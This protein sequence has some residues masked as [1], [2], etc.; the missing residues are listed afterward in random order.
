MSSRRT[1]SWERREF[2]SS[3]APVETIEEAVVLSDPT[4]E[5]AARLL[6]EGEF[7]QRIT[8]VKMAAV[9]GAEPMPLYSLPAVANFIRVS[10]GESF[11]LQC[12]AD[13]GCR[14]T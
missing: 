10:G 7:D 8:G 1:R 13:V 4:P 12:P 9:G 11:V 14:N 2:M 6:A 3:Q 5:M